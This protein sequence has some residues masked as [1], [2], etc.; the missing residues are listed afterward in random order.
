ML[1]LSDVLQM[2][3]AAPDAASF[4]EKVTELHLSNTHMASIFEVAVQITRPQEDQGSHEMVAKI[5][6]DV[7][8]V[9]HYGNKDIGTLQLLNN[10]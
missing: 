10:T 7:L 9:V 8:T 2:D 5:L 4:T 3:S 6:A 1:L